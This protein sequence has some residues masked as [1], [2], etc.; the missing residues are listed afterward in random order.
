VWPESWRATP[1][2]QDLRRLRFRAGESRR[3]ILFMGATSDWIGD[4]GDHEFGA[5]P[6]DRA[7][8]VP[9][10]RDAERREFVQP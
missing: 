7:V 4:T 6:C 1:R 2:K 5:S 3:Q 10:E 9:E 8:L